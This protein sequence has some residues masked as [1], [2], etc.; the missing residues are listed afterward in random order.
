MTI[1]IKEIDD[2]L[3]KFMNGDPLSRKESD[4][5]FNQFNFKHRSRP[6]YRAVRVLPDGSEARNDHQFVSASM[7]AE[8]ALAAAKSYSHDWE[9]PYSYSGFSVYRI[10]HPIV[11]VSH[12]E[13]A[14][15][16]KRDP[17]RRRWLSALL[18]AEKEHIIV[19]CKWYEKTLVLSS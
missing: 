7:T 12:Q 1:E 9:I 19:N 17:I 15:M 5:L 8:N 11:L 18:S 14:H 4:M 10:H 3:S 16:I 2:V 6:L 13:L